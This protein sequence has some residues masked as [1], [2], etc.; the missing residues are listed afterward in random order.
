[1]HEDLAFSILFAIYRFVFGSS[2]THSSNSGT[3][4]AMVEVELHTVGD[5]TVPE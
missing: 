4:D 2:K 5:S 1:M 3:W